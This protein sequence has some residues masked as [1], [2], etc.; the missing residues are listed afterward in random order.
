MDTAM[1][2][3]DNEKGVPLA[4]KLAKAAAFYTAKH[5][6]T[7]NLCFVNPAMLAEPAS[8]GG[9][10]VRTSRGIM[11]NHFWIGVNDG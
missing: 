9:V 7:P 1:M 8:I 10:D 3:F 5:G 11:P 4:D 2:W 6:K